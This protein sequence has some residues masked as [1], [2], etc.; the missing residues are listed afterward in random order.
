A[1]PRDYV[2]V[3]F[4]GAAG[5]HACA[6]AR[7]L[8]MQQI[9]NHPDAGLLSAYGIGMADVSRHRAAGIYRDY[10]PGL[11]AELRQRFES[12]QRE[13]R[14]EVLHEGIPPERIEVRRSLDLRYRGLDSFLTIP[15]LPGDDWVESYAAEHE[16]LY[17]YRQTDRPV[18]VVAAR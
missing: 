4:G 18:E 7:E 17:G 16:R 14:D 8:G 2:L 10:E 9:L 5:Q 12:L 15:E 11:E 3:A 13:A 6:V 1:D